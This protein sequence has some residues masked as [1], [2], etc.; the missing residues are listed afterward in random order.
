MAKQSQWVAVGKR[1]LELTNPDK[2][3]FPE[4][5]I[6]KAEVMEYYLKMAPTMLAH[7]KG[8][9]LTLVRYPDG[10]HGER[11]YQKNRPDWAPVWVEFVPLGTEE[12]KD[13]II[14]T[15][16]ATLAW[17]ANLAALEIHQL[18]SRR[19]NLLCPDYL[20]FDLD[21][22]EGYPFA[23]VIEIAVHLRRHLETYGY[24]VWVKTTGGKGLHLVC[25]IEPE[26]PFSAV[27]EATREL[28]VPFAALHSKRV[29]L[30]LRKDARNGKLLLDIYRMRQGQSIV[31]PYS[32]RGRAG[33]PVSMPLTW[34]ELE[35][36]SSPSDFN[37]RNVPDKLLR[38]GDAWQGIEA[39]AVPLHTHRTRPVTQE[40]PPS[41]KRKSP[42][43]LEAYRSKRNFSKTAEPLPTDHQT[44]NHR[45]VI[46]RHHASHLHYDLRLE[47][48]GVLKCWA[49]PKGL[50]PYPGVKRLAVQTEDHPV[51]YLSFEGT[52]PKGQ[53]GGGEMWM[54]LAGKYQITKEKKDGFYFRL[55]SSVQ[56]AEYRIHRMKNK[57][58]LLERV[59]EPQVNYLKTFVP[60]MLA[61]SAAQLP[62]GEDWMYEVKWDG[63]RAMITL[64]EGAL[65]IRSRNGRD[66]TD[67]F[68]ELNTDKAFYATNAV[69]DTE[70]VC[71][72]KAGRPDFKNVMNRLTA[73]G[74][75]QIQRLMQSQPVCCYV[76]DCLYLDGRPLGMEPLQKRKMW[77]ADVLR[78]ST[79]YRLSEWVTEG[80]LLLQAASEHHLEGIMA[81]HRNSKYQPGRRTS[82]WLKI[83]WR[84]TAECAIIGYT[85]GKGNRAHTFGSLH[86][87]EWEG[88][89][90]QY[91]GKVGTGFDDDTAAA[92]SAML[93]EAEKVQKPVLQKVPDEKSSVWVKPHLMAEISYVSRTA[94]G[95]FREPVF[96]RLRPDLSV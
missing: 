35:S 41:Q 83:K 44:H 14:A 59:D 76:F 79:P 96:V 67:R 80:N 17:L 86:L 33:A 2:L 77:L 39:M 46:H 81:K 6:I 43:Q 45:F 22:P 51:A 19:P 71:L 31:S 5:G 55:S 68:P 3:L 54:Y 36:L 26:H 32:L 62:E 20:L 21:P 91:R 56:T 1:R 65:T 10:I 89:T 23:D 53:Y 11:F 72:D 34:A 88:G 57:E 84:N 28:A 73:S 64:D 48:H 7:I 37:L 78:K 24:H 52:I 25:P 29:T 70:I 50:P 8:R 58:Y 94:N 85:T 49:L 60:P 75:M 13:Y 9:P 18:H 87:A 12:Q 93:K 61:E 15:E 90:W 42:D 27:F 4:D 63:I 16:A 66:I 40:L 82:E 47:H 95:M 69:F 92:L 74:Q 30:Q 38:D